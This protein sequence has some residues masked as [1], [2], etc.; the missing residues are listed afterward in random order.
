LYQASPAG[1]SR[2][3]LSQDMNETWPGGNTTRTQCWELPF[4]ILAYGIGK[5]GANRS[6]LIRRIKSSISLWTFVSREVRAVLNARLEGLTSR[7]VPQ[8]PFTLKIPSRLI[9][10]ALPSVALVH[11]GSS[12]RA[13]MPLSSRGVADSSPSISRL[14]FPS[15]IPIYRSQK[16][17]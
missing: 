9:V 10:H 14:E 4:G 8:T 7:A 2:Q 1:K 3:F 11:F 12:S 16:G 15:R 13:D 6:T 17:F 5:Q